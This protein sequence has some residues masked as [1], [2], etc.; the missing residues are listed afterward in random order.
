MSCL[1]CEDSGWVCENHPDQPFTGTHACSCGGAGMPCPKC[2]PSSEDE[3]PRLPKW[4]EPDPV[5]G[6][7]KLPA[8]TLTFGPCGYLSGYLSCYRR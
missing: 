6:D 5:T 8:E 1:L 2:N 7:S 3:A 4:F